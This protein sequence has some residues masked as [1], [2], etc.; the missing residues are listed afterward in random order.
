MNTRQRS[1]ASKD[2]S[3]GSINANVLIY[4]QEIKIGCIKQSFDLA[5][6]FKLTFRSDLQ[7][8]FQNYILFYL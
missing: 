8:H 1:K 5:I 7:D 6:Y 2:P 4:Q 3:F